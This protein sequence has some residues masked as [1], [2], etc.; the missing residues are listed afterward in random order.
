MSGCFFLKHGVQCG[1]PA[2][3]PVVDHAD[4][5]SALHSRNHK[6]RIIDDW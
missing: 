1:R 4:R 5:C 2:I 6:R 3:N